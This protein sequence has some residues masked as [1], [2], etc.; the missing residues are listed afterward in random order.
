MYKSIIELTAL[1]ELS[2]GNT[3]LMLHYLLQVEE[4]TPKRS[5]ETK[6]IV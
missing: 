3:G 6:K 1:K 2:H 4:L 5:S